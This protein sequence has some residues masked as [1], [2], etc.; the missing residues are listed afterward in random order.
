MHSI[1]IDDH[2]EFELRFIVDGT[3]DE[4]AVNFFDEFGRNIVIHLVSRFRE[5]RLL[6]NY[7]V[8]SEW[9]NELTIPHEWSLGD[10]L[11]VTLTLN[12][13]RAM[14]RGPGIDATFPMPE[15]Y[16]VSDI[17]LLQ[18]YGPLSIRRIDIESSAVPSGESIRDAVERIR[19]EIPPEPEPTLFD[20]HFDEGFYR[21]QEPRI[22][23]SVNALSHFCTIGWQSSRN[24]SVEF[25]VDYYLNAYPDVRAA[26]VNPFLHYLLLGKS[27]GRQPNAY[28]RD[29]IQ[30]H[31]DEQYYCSQSPSLMGMEPIEHY[32]VFGW[33]QGLRA[34]STFDDRFYLRL[35]PDVRGLNCC[36]LIH[37]LE[38]GQDD[39]SAT[40]P[41]PRPR[42]ATDPAKGTIVFVGHDGIRA[43]AQLVLRDIVQWFAQHTPYSIQVLLLEPGILASQYALWADTLVLARDEDPAGAI[44]GEFIADSIAFSYVNTVAASRFGRAIAA[45]PQLSGRPLVFHIHEMPSVISHFDGDDFRS[46][47]AHARQ[48]IAVSQ[49]TRACL[50]DNYGVSES[51]VD[52]VHAFLSANSGPEDEL[53]RG[54][55]LERAR[56]GARP[57][58]VVIAGCGTVYSR[59]GPDLFV[60][61]ALRVLRRVSDVDIR[62]VWYGDGADRGGLEASLKSTPFADRIVFPGFMPDSRRRLAACDVFF[63]SSRE[64]PF[65]LVV[66]EAA[67]GGAPTVCFGPATGITEFLRDDAGCV[68]DEIDVDEAA[69]ALVDLVSHERK[70]KELGARAR[71]RALYEYRSDQ[72]ILEL[73]VCLRAR[74]NLAPSVSVI[75]PTYNHELYVLERLSSI[76]KQS[77]KDVEIILLDDCSTDN[78]LA[79]V[80]DQFSDPRLFTVE[81]ESNSGS[82]FHQWKK[83]L[84]LAKAPY[85]WIAEGDDYCTTNFLEEL[86]PLVR[87]DGVAL[88][89]A[90][91]E[92]VDRHSTLQKGAI[93]GYLSRAHP[94]KYQS[95]YFREGYD[96][97][98]ESFAH[99]CSIVNASAVVFRKALVD[100]KI[101]DIATK[102]RM[103]G[104]WLFYLSLLRVG[105][106]A[107]TI[108]ATNFFRRHPQS[109]VH[110][111][112]GTGTYFSER[113]NITEYILENFSVSRRTLRR[114]FAEIDNEWRRFAAKNCDDR[115]DTYFDKQ[116]LLTAYRSQ[117]ERRLRIAVYV[118]GILFSKGG[119]E[120]LISQLSA[121]WLRRGHAVDI[122]CRLWGTDQPAYRF[123]SGVRIVPCFDEHDLDNSIARMRRHLAEDGPDVFIAMLSEWLFAPVVEA[124][125]GLGIPIVVSEHN[126]PWVICEKWW[127][128]DER[129]ATFAKADGIHL[130]LQNFVSSIAP[131]LQSRVRVIPNGIRTDL[132]AVA[133]GENVERRKR[134]IGVGRLAPQKRF[135]RLI[136]A[137]SLVANDFPDWSLAIFGEGPE[138]PALEGLAAVAHCAERISLPGAIDNIENE[139]AAS[140]IFVIPSEFEGFGIVVLEAKRAGLPAIGFADC[141]GPNELI[142]EGVDGLLVA[143]DGGDEVAALAAAMRKLMENGKKRQKMGIAAKAGL[144]GFSISEIALQWENWLIEIADAHDSLEAW[145][146]ALETES[147]SQGTRARRS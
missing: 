137:F 13:S 90:K 64:D 57:D 53:L 130:L 40:Q 135:D 92:N 91:T 119:I 95:G 109:V 47:L 21:A 143:A 86:V 74:L 78:T 111:I 34:S 49:T 4:P 6:F 99:M 41:T 37:Y 77:F 30:D 9:N 38:A 75:V 62:F 15:G 85:I 10:S 117:S 7:R 22:D 115:L 145:G 50:V 58:T 43:G 129:A 20:G 84:G 69:D 28:A 25:D 1:R 31:F 76:A 120:R 98:D 142:H 36:P 23:P 132:H 44:V 54:R 48:I 73:F 89:H 61:T 118:H 107:Y 67:E 144:K 8:N 71:L 32:M 83:G 113:F 96:E 104:D 88:A 122:Y 55:L 52:V 63:L 103:C 79:T 45:L 105:S 102:F 121:A 5:N 136:R 126:D 134:I 3:Q 35:N 19:A 131:D 65:P 70:R 33:K 116:K 147:L 59:K 124:A 68:L 101:L 139:Y 82:P 97:V 66:L 18:H 80:Q 2:A 27:Q 11:T 26:R 87:R 16:S 138:R 114:I 93:D 60:D 42:M 133:E 110:Q 100:V 141:N 127:N 106:I 29:L 39:G 128:K 81:N 123:E 146:R 14:L 125:Y 94:T 17:R 12:D 56:L 112:E 24:P 108:N 140:E 46:L 51:R 72:K